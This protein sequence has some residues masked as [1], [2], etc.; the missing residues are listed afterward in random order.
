MFNREDLLVVEETI[1]NATA[2][3]LFLEPVNGP[4]EVELLFS[5]SNAP[6]PFSPPRKYPAI[7][8]GF[9]ITMETGTGELQGHL[10]GAS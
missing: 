9:V 8:L 3:P 10:D 7:T 6:N 2:T 4:E 5:R 1:V